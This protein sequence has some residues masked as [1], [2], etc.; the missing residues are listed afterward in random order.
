MQRGQQPPRL[1]RADNVVAHGL[2]SE[3]LQQLTQHLARYR[4]I[5]EG[6]L[7]RREAAW[8]G[9]PMYVLALLIKQPPASCSPMGCRPATGLIAPRRSAAACLIV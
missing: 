1:T 4:P 9:R 8:Q 3:D 6:F 2:S 5:G 7:V